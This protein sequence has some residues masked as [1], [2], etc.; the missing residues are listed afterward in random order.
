MII[1]QTKLDSP[2][3]MLQVVTVQAYCQSSPGKLV[4]NP[5]EYIEYIPKA[6][7]VTNLLS[8][9]KQEYWTYGS[10]CAIQWS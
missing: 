4:P 5:V 9:L 3:Y 1:L 7:T 10:S 8:E 6:P 2:S